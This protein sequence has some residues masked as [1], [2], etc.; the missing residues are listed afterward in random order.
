M[1]SPSQSYELFKKDILLSNEL[2]IWCRYTTPCYPSLTN[3]PLWLDKH[4]SLMINARRA[5]YRKKVMSLILLK[6][7]FFLSILSLFQDF[8]KDIRAYIFPMHIKTSKSWLILK[9]TTKSW[10]ILK[11]TNDLSQTALRFLPGLLLAASIRSASSASCFT[12][13]FY[14]DL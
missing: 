12:Y 5:K 8:K 3:R 6:A 4:C 10:L 1:S 9:S 7:N 13:L 14:F 2:C 11:S